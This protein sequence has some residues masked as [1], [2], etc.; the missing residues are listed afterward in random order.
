[1]NPVQT[2]RRLPAVLA[3]GAVFAGALL[4]VVLV[5]HR[6]DSPVSAVQSEQP[7]PTPSASGSPG[8][9]PAPSNP[10][11][12]ATLGPDETILCGY[13][14]IKGS[15][16]DEIREAASLA[17]DKTLDGLKERL[18]A[19][20]DPAE[21][22]LG[23]YMKGSTDAL[24][25]TAT[26]HGDP[27][28]Y[29]LAF[30]SCQYGARGACALLS[31][32]QWAAIEPDNGIPWLFVAGAAGADK[33]AR[34]QA[35]VRAAAARYLD[36][37]LP[38]FLAMLRWPAVRDQPPQTRAA[39]ANQ[40]MAMQMSLPMV[41]YA[42]FIQYCSDPAVDPASRATSCGNL[43]SLLLGDRSLLGFSTG[44]KLAE[45]AGS[46]PDR[47][48]ALLQKRDEYRAVHAR[49]SPSINEPASTGPCDDLAQFE[50]WAADYSSRGEIGVAIKRME[51]GRARADA[52]RT[53]R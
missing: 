28:V 47:V 27:R 24:V 11:A 34:N 2:K 23:L 49:V 30:L 7:Q 16:A 48:H 41:S 10:E 52:A 18:A 40:L 33:E 53:R 51:E 39:L 9:I 6:P 38:D 8:G 21:A 44:V 35:V 29:A 22:A 43:S 14:R 25:A 36:Q 19:S 32:Q 26:G 4:C 1:M 45:L 50:Q 37:R 3:G 46:P 17:A 31:A 13:G 15:D 12:A 20:K 5:T 42:P